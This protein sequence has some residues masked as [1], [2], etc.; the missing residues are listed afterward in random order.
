M[1]SPPRRCDVA[2][3]GPIRASLPLHSDVILGILHRKLHFDVTKTT[4]KS[5]F[6]QCVEEVTCRGEMF[7]QQGNQ[8]M[9]NKGIVRDSGEPSSV[10]SSVQVC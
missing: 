3:C 5:C 8:A 9:V 10:Y 1:A 2:N 4:L 7:T 6:S